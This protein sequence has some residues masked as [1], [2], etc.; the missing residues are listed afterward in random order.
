MFPYQ[1]QL[2]KKKKKLK[3]ELLASHGDP[4]HLI[5]KLKVECEK[6]IFLVKLCYQHILCIS[7]FKDKHIGF[8]GSNMLEVKERR[9]F[10]IV[11]N[12]V[13]RYFDKPLI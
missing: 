8:L 9:I 13:Y 12:L 10:R 6:L 7:T 2:V 1:G 3:K 4:F 5:L 11:Y